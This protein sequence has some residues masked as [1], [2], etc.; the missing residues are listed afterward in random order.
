MDTK[1]DLSIHSAVYYSTAIASASS[2]LFGMSLTVLGCMR[3]LVCKTW[4]EAADEQAADS[5]W[6]VVSGNIFLGC[7]VSNI[8]VSMARPNKK[9][10]L[11]WNNFLHAAGYLTFLYS[12]SFTSMLV[13]RLLTGLASGVTCAVVPVYITLIA[14]PKHRGFLLS[15]HP[16]GIITG[17]TVGNIL[18]CL[19]SQDT[20]RLP[21]LSMLSLL[22]ANFI[23]ISNMMDIPEETQYSNASLL[24][25]LQKPRARKSILL[26]ALVHMSQHLCGVD[27]V[28][29]FLGNIFSTYRHSRMIVIGISSFAILV[30]VA[31]TRCVDLVGRKP[32]IMASSLIA[33]VATAMLAFRLCPP[34]A[35]LLFM[36]G[37]NMGLGSIPWFIT[38]EIFPQK[39]ANPA[40]LLTVSLNWMSAYV[41][42]TLLYPLHVKYGEI[43][44]LS[45]TACMVLF[46][47]LM[48]L[49]FKETKGKTP[50]F[51]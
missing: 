34:L 18:A 33:A 4:A 23:A 46:L 22:S 43:T 30:T 1:Q 29:L 3:P 14:P 11:L 47:G 42:V 8:L 10:A 5:R 36:L 13:G 39:Y 12:R 51:Q 49:V 24:N 19:D 27:Y 9:R 40:G 2:L 48:C 16:L 25:L 15:F 20:W 37:Y 21:I 32:L 41:A 44:F 31:F 26:A 38:T 6:G 17:I 7:L 45:Y 50:N 28:T 35:A